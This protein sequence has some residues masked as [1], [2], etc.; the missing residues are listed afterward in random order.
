[1]TKS[2]PVEARRATAAAGVPEDA[3]IGRLNRREAVLADRVGALSGVRRNVLH[4]VQLLESHKRTPTARDAADVDKV[5]ARYKETCQMNRLPLLAAVLACAPLASCSSV[6]REIAELNGRERELST[7]IATLQTERKSVLRLIT[8]LQECQRSS[9]GR[10]S[11]AVAKA[12][13]AY[14]AVK[15]E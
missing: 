7:Q 13:E 5:V 14:A 3:E 6:D 11:V 1:M 8:A 12:R 15:T 10:N 2:P 4:L 9:D